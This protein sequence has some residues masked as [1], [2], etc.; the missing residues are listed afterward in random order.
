MSSR[1]SS[2]KPTASPERTLAGFLTAAV[3]LIV[4]AIAQGIGTRGEPTGTGTPA[5][6][7]ATQTP[8]ATPTP[9]VE[10]I[11]PPIELIT[12]T[13]AEVALGPN[14][15]LVAIPGGYSVG[16]FR[17]Y[18]TAPTNPKSEAE[19]VGSPV[20]QA[21]VD[22]INSATQTVDAAMFEFNSAPVR[23]AL[24]AAH[25]R[26]VAV[27]IVTD[28]DA[29]MDDPDSLMPDLEFAGIP[30][31]SDGARGGLMHDKFFVV[32]G[33]WVWTGST[34]VTRNG[35]YTNNNNALIIQSPAL[36]A[37]YADEFDELFAKRFGKTSPGT[38]NRP[39]IDVSGIPVEVFFESEEDVVPRL[40]ALIRDATTLR[41]M[42]FSF[43]PG[44]VWTDADGRQSIMDLI[45]Q[46]SAAGLDVSGIVEASSRRF[47]KTLSCAGVDVRQDG[48]PS[49]FHHKVMIIN[50]NM[51]VTGSFNF[52]E[53][54]ANNNDE[55]LLIIHSPALARAYLE[56]FQRRWAES[57]RIP[58]STFTC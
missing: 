52:S 25:Q 49:V 41:F 31:I 39:A 32:D 35:F 47:V 16:A 5:A 23:D 37:E 10:L 19:M 14:E 7:V 6:A 9:T 18:F 51:V 3:I 43:T 29:G 26:Q 48:N 30:V 58:S 27:R 33:Q 22:L 54:A 53:G 2:R 11:E 1:N 50:D 55:N 17:V 57:K 38:P 46:R 34:N 13:P 4:V 8:A 28:G 12:P 42:A 15:T 56:E 21:L 40:A 44:L 24:I 36:A 45:A 20:E